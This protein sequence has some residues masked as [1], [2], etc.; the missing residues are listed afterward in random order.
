MIVNYLVGQ[1]QADHFEWPHKD[2]RRAVMVSLI[3][4]LMIAG[5][6]VEIVVTGSE[7]GRFGGEV[8]ITK[9]G[10]RHA[11]M[12]SAEQKFSTAEDIR[13]KMQGVVD[14]IKAHY[15]D[16]MEEVMRILRGFE[17]PPEV[18]ETHG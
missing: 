18:G 12:L 3:T 16:R 13:S 11:L 9:K 6:D 17:A 8:W 1:R 4:A 5:N 2:P 14:D 7:E 15:A 10:E